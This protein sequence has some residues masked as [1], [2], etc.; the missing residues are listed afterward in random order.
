MDNFE[1]DFSF[2]NINSITNFIKENFIQ[3][4]MLMS[5]FVIIYLVDY[6]AFINSSLYG[7]PSAIPGLINQSNTI[8]IHKKKKYKKQIYG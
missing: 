7:L 1:E 3:I 2:W 5:V 8:N 6:I 4:L